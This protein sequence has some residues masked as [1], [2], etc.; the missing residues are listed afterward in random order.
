MHEKSRT[1]QEGESNRSGSCLLCCIPHDADL[2]RGAR[3]ASWIKNSVE[4]L[5]GC[6]RAVIRRA[7]TSRLAD[8]PVDPQHLPYSPAVAV[9]LVVGEPVQI[10]RPY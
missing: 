1:I 10:P 6:W 4:S 3:A 2:K 9:A 8:L 5:V 7:R